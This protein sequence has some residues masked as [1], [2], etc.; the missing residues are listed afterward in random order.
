M[1]AKERMKVEYNETNCRDLAEE[2]AQVD[3]G[4]DKDVIFKEMMSDLKVFKMFAK[5]RAGPPRK[6][7]KGRSK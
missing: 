5:E 2:M 6:S 1:I 4:I 3:R 7:M